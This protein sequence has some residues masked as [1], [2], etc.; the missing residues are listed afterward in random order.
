MRKQKLI[1][2][3]LIL[4]VHLYSLSSFGVNMRVVQHPKVHVVRGQIAGGYNR[5]RDVL[6]TT[7]DRFPNQGMPQGLDV[8][9]NYESAVLN[10]WKQLI[11]KPLGLLAQGQTLL[12]GAVGRADLSDGVI[13]R[14]EQIYVSPDQKM[15]VSR[16]SAGIVRIID[17]I[18][19][20][21]VKSLSYNGTTFGYPDGI[22]AVSN[23]YFVVGENY[24]S[25]G[26]SSPSLTIR[27]LSDPSKIIGKM[28]IG[29]Q[30]PTGI[31]FSRDERTLVITDLTFIKHFNL[32]TG[33]SK[34]IFQFTEDGTGRELL[35]SHG[36]YIHNSAL[37]EDGKTLI[38]SKTFPTSVMFYNLET[39]LST[40]TYRINAREALAFQK[41]DLEAMT[42]ELVVKQ[43]PIEVIELNIPAAAE[44]RFQLKTASYD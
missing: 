4:G 9:I 41:I 31:S 30:R 35:D 7:S 26:G 20:K 5:D 3:T 44:Y 21:L 1:I 6:T 25:D 22:L 33:V 11:G 40:R 29:N 23:K 17:A 34:T 13:E 38:I 15:V 37:L 18:T 16:S 42:M 10:H 24:K 32:E 43:E 27:S 28:N 8:T 12:R 39:G 19:G 14:H 2:S 36:S